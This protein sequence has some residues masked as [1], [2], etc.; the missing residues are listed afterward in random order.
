MQSKLLKN[1]NNNFKLI[2]NPKRITLYS[3]FALYS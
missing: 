1:A 2:R 3:Y